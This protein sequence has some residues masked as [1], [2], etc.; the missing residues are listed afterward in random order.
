MVAPVKKP[1]SVEAGLF[2]KLVSLVQFARRN[3]EGAPGSFLEDLIDACVMECYFREH[4][5]DRDLLFHDTVAR[6]LVAYD[7]AASEAKQREFLAR[8]HATLNASSHGFTEILVT[9]S[10]TQQYA[11]DDESDPS[12]GHSTQERPASRRAPTNCSRD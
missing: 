10:D 4:M 5:K 12:P 6:H 3:G 2:E 8:L 7:S 1:T 9:G 11:I